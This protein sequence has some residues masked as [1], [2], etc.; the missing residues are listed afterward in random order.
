[1]S[2]D[3]NFEWDDKYINDIMFVEMSPKEIE[4]A[5]YN[6]KRYIIVVSRRSGG[7]VPPVISILSD[8]VE[9]IMNL[10]KQLEQERKQRH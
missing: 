8:A 4:E 6:A 9:A 7:I 3:P 5:T 10:Q 2:Y 1:M